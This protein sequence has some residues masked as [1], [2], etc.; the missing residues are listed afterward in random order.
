MLSTV[1]GF[2]AGWQVK[3]AIVLVVISGL[4]FWHKYEV[5]VAVNEA[6]SAQQLEYQ[7]EKFKLLDKA[8]DATIALRDKAEQNN[9]DK[10]AKIKTLNARVST[11][12]SSLRNRPERPTSTSSVPGSTSTAESL[13]GATGVQLYR[14]DGEFL[15]WFAGQTTQLQV[16][17]QTC[18]KQYDEV[19]DSLDKFK[20]DNSSRIK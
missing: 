4:F 2:F 7:K 16:E 12:A 10:D 3:L 1:M 14:P 13:K 20:K 5:K 8:N 9:K 18:Y 11:L 19:K 15:V 17:L 6:I